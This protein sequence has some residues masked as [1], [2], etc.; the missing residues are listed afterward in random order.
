MWD[1][2]IMEGKKHQYMLSFIKENIECFLT[3]V[4]FPWYW[5]FATSYYS[6]PREIS[7]VVQN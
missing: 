7:I 3:T 2:I 4:T 6:H 1:M 5:N